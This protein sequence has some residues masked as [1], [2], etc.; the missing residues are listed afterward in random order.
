MQ[1]V[2]RPG[3][4]VTLHGAE[5]PRAI[6]R[7]GQSRGLQARVCIL[8]QQRIGLAHEARRE[9]PAGVQFV[10]VQAD[11]PVEGLDQVDIT[12]LALVG[13]GLLDFQS[14]RRRVAE[15]GDVE[16]ALATV[17]FDLEHVTQQVI[18]LQFDRGADDGITIT[19][20]SQVVQAILVGLEAQNSDELADAGPAEWFSCAPVP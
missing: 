9:A 10:D 18:A 16:Q 19:V 8:R 15:L 12:L 7:L 20:Q 2:T 13:A 1:V 14:I 6:V 5:P 4:H 11:Q 3:A 17:G